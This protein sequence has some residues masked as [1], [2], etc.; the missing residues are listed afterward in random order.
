MTDVQA[1]ARWAADWLASWM[2]IHDWNGRDD[3]SCELAHIVA[4]FYYIADNGEG[5]E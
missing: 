3:A 1:H 2:R 5:D 4:E